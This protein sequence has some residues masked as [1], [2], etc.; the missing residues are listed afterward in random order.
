MPAYM[1]QPIDAL[2]AKLGFPTKQDTIAG[3]T[4][5]IWSTGQFIEGTSYGCTIRA[6]VNA[7]SV[8]D[9][10]DYIGNEGQCMRYAALL[11]R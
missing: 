7:Q 8:I 9:H 11:G 3:E 10:W 2:I 6:I 4:V 1:G 5:Y